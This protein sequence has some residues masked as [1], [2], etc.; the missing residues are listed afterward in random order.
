MNIG[1]LLH[2]KLDIDTEHICVNISTVIADYN[3]CFIEYE[4]DQKIGVYITGND[5]KERFLIIYKE[6]IV[7]LQ[8]VY[9]ED[10][11]IGENGDDLDVMVG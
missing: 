5:G 3:L 4:D 10:I 6:A 1:E 11:K 8:V 2:D 9:Q 7:S